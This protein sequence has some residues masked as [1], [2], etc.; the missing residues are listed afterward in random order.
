[1][2]AFV[3]A[4][5]ALALAAPQM[6]EARRFGMRGGGRSRAASPAPRAAPAP[7]TRPPAGAVAAP[8]AATPGAH[9]AVPAPDRSRPGTYYYPY[10]YPPYAYYPFLAAPF[11]FGWGWGYGWYPL[12]P[13]PE[14]P[15]RDEELHRITTELSIRAGPTRE[16]L[17]RQNGFA[18]NLA[19]SIDGE[20]LG[21][22]GEIAGF[23]L[24]GSSGFDSSN[25]MGLGTAHLTY[26]ILASDHGRLRIDLGGSIVSWPD[27]ALRTGAMAFGPDVGL[28]GR[29][30]LVGPLGVEGHARVTP[31]P[32]AV[33]DLEGAL[34][35]RFG[36]MAV[37]GGWRHVFVDG[38]A[39]LPSLRFSGPE[40]G[41][42][43]LF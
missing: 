16:H 42:A 34:A 26:A 32:H 7:A 10:A 23:A 5:L 27:T 33:T 8:G 9:P 41:L 38:D 19:L 43:V 4:T 35:F 29:L 25:A 37:T 20:R 11:W 36:A 18:G 40:F 17:S 2:R 15:Y 30:S 24:N 14:Y 28:S 6:A 31:F 12:Y 1:M 3:A 39:T 22:N 21:F 13:R